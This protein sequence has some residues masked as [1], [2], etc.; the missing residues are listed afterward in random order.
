MARRR[1]AGFVCDHAGRSLDA[2]VSTTV[3]AQSNRDMAHQISAST[4][5]RKAGL[6]K[7]DQRGDGTGR[8]HHIRDEV[9]CERRCNPVDRQIVWVWTGGGEPFGMLPNSIVARHE[10]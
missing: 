5:V 9:V 1:S 7:V 8:E 3:R 6:V 10:D 2:I 4:G